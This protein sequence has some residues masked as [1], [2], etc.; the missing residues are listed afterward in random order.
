M[1]IEIKLVRFLL[2]A[3]MSLGVPM[4]RAQG[5]PSHL[6]YPVAPRQPVV[7]TYH[8]VKVADDYQWLE[9][10]AKPETLAWVAQQN[11]FTRAALDAVAGREWVQ[12]RVRSLVMSN[13]RSYSLLGFKGGVWFAMKSEPPKQQDFLVTLASPDKPQ[14]E[15]VVIDPNAMAADGSIAIDWAVPSPDGRLVAVSMSRNGSEDGSLHVFDVATSQQVEPEIPRVQYPT[16]GGSVAWRPDSKSFYYTRFPAPGERAE[17][18]LHF[19]QQ[20]YLHRIGEP[21]AKDHYILGK[22]FA[23]I[24]EIHLESADTGEQVAVVKNGD[25]GEASVYLQ[26]RGVWK[27]VALDSDGMK[28]ALF[29]E[30]G[31]LYLLSRKNAPR[32]KVLRV[33]L[34]APMLARAQT[35]LA[36]GEGTIQNMA[37]AGGRLLVSSVL[38]GPSD[39]AVIDLGTRARSAIELP[40]V[41]SVDSLV[42]GERGEVMALVQS[43]TAPP[44]WYRITPANT[45]DKTA[46]AM[47]S[48]ADYAD[49]EV[50]RDHAV[51]KDGTRVPLSIIR[52]K[53]TKLDGNNP[54]ILYG[55]GGY[56][57][58]E[59]PY[60]STGRRVWLDQGGVYVLAN[61]RG[62][63]EFGEA[64]HL[65]GNLTKKQNVFD[66]F[67]ASAEHLIA[68]GY[69]SPRK[70]AIQGGSNGGLLMGAALTQRPD[71][72]SAVHS[73]VGIYDM[74]RVELDP[75]GAFNVTEFGTVKNKAQFDALYAYSPFH[76]V[77]DGTSYPAVLMT[78]GD[79]DGR[80][81]PAHS[82]KMVARLQAANPDGSPI[83]LRT[84]T[85][86][87]HGIGS[88][89]N[90]VID[91]RTDTF[92]FL[93]DQLS[94]EI[95]APR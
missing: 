78:T 5:A 18:D 55:Y 91:E 70:L 29:G 66:D 6:H 43:Y 67:V 76:H 35:V 65:E 12:E 71:L 75:N 27:P 61:V 74:L 24:A 1:S 21:A 73:T 4:C 68:R 2:L 3:A 37:V 81:N 51:S 13:S 15:K 50:L 56:G 88:S 9:D 48:D 33:S 60:F 52:R 34:G 19:Y 46:L 85:A 30:D 11:Q 93:F 16:A 36:E 22:R 47:T 54:T 17:A 77:R 94:V 59:T 92:C 57:V 38:G 72:F 25:G 62:G 64:W 83:L 20:I 42:K 39:L 28:D 8:G 90:E 82:R 89:L 86:S 79:N 49:T 95:K 53:G 7:D 41:S 26:S 40:A 32:G 69:T 23:R 45:I 63:G 31:W 10:S 58:S 14:S 87:G 44:A 80:V 84:S